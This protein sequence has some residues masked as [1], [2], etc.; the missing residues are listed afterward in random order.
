MVARIR[1]ETLAVIFSRD[2]EDPE[3]IIAENGVKAWAHAIRLIGQRQE[4]HAGDQLLVQHYD[5]AG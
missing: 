1:I 4:L 2:G 3:T 5:A